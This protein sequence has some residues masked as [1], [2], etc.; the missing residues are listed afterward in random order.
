MSHEDFRLRVFEYLDKLGGGIVPVQRYK[1]GA[2]I[3]ARFNHFHIGCVIAHEHANCVI[4]ADTMVCKN[5]S[6]PLRAGLECVPSG[7]PAF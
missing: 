4:L 1:I 2:Q 3:A 5:R 7:F 6:E